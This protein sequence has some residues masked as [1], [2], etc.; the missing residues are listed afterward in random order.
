MITI[1]YLERNTRWY[2]RNFTL[3]HQAI[4]ILCLFL[5]H[6]WK[7]NTKIYLLKVWKLKNLLKSNIFMFCITLSMNF[8][9]YLGFYFGFLKQ[10]IPLTVLKSM[11][12]SKNTTEDHEK[13]PYGQLFLSK[14]Y[15]LV[16]PMVPLKVYGTTRKWYGQRK[17]LKFS[18]WSWYHMVF[19]QSQ[20][21]LH[22]EFF[23]R[24]SSK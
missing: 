21:P 4:K 9:S 23:R 14:W 1:W 6:S 20:I 24:F 16:P 22:C 13:I 8:W 5:A 17:I 12:P 10:F 7:L 3:Y 11:V 19:L 18:R 2:H 15:H